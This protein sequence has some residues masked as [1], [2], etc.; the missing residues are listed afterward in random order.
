MGRGITSDVIDAMAAD[1]NRPFYLVAI[2]LASTT[3][4]LSTLNRDISWSSQ[5]W[6]GNGQLRGF[7]AVREGRDIAADGI[8]VKIAGEPSTMISIALQSVRQNKPA[9]LYL[10]YLDSS[11]AVIADPV[12]LFKG[13]VDTC[14]I[15]DQPD[16]A[17]VSFGIE[18]RLVNL[19]R[20]SGLRFNHQSQQSIFP[21]DLGFQYVEFLQ[22]YSWYW[23]KPGKNPRRKRRRRNRG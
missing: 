11:L 2:E 21:G 15:V 4:R 12:V 8:E 14:K 20:A 10:G 7:G 6:L 13:V 16:V 3:L 22:D 23:G 17:T 9:T 5:T 1:A 19:Q 18:S